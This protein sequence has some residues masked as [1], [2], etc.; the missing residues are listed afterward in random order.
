MNIEFCEHFDNTFSDSCF[1]TVLMKVGLI[2]PDWYVLDKVERKNI[3]KKERNIILPSTD[4]LEAIDR[5]ITSCQYKD[6]VTGEEI[7]YYW[8]KI[9][10]NNC[11]YDTQ[12]QYSRGCS[13][14]SNNIK[15]I[16]KSNK[17]LEDFLNK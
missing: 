12:K 15:H 7:T 10:R 6:I 9:Q 16:V 11:N 4:T 2:F 8:F 17:E 13:I 5:F 3:T 1:R 14:R